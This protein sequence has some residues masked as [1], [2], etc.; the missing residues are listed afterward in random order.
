MATNWKQEAGRVGV[1][2]EVGMAAIHERN[3][4]FRVMFRHH[5]KQ[6]NFT[7]GK[8]S[9]GEAKAKADQGEYLLMCSIRA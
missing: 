5:G 2:L 6:R 7:L 9:E 3:G 8:V 4:N 1:I